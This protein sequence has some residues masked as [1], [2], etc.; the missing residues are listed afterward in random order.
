MQSNSA[1]LLLALLL[2]ASSAPPAHGQVSVEEA[3]RRLQAKLAT[4]PS[5]TRPS[6]ELERLHEEN[7]RLREQ[8]IALERQVTTLKE[9]LARANHAT[10]GPVTRPTSGPSSIPSPDEPQKPLLGLWRGGD[11]IAGT[12]Y[13]IQ[14]NPDGTYKQT[15]ITQNAKETGQYRVS[16]DN[17]MEMWSD[18]WPE[19]KKHNQYKV[20]ATPELITLTPLV[21]DGF[22]VK[23]PRAV[24]LRHAE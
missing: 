3:E 23:S 9:S 17:T 16:D 8:V 7:R 10:P 24:V 21:L 15:F 1:R 4:R 5:T 19:T 13:L 11:L 14:F 6:A 18:T 20:A 2:F 22:P 12:R